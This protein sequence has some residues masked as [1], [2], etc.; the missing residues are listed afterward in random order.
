MI[1]TDS[2]EFSWFSRM[3]LTLNFYFDNSVAYFNSM[4][5]DKQTPKTK[6]RE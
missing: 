2:A 6:K 4:Q 3:N 1:L 5:M